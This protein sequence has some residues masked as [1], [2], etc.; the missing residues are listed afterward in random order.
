MFELLEQR[1]IDANRSNFSFI[2]ADNYTRVYSHAL[3]NLVQKCVSVNPAHRPH[4]NE[5]LYETNAGLRN[6]QT[7]YGRVD[8]EDVDERWTWEYR[9]E[10]FRIGEDAPRHWRWGTEEVDEPG[11]EFDDEDDEDEDM[12]TRL[13]SLFEEEVGNEGIAGAGAGA[14]QQDRTPPQ[15]KGKGKAPEEP[16]PAPASNAQ[17]SPSAN[18]LKVV[19]KFGGHAIVER[20]LKGMGS[21]KRK[22]K[23]RAREEGGEAEVEQPVQDAEEEPAGNLVKREEHEKIVENVEV[24]PAEKLNEEKEEPDQ[25]VEMRPLGDK[26]RPSADAHASGE[27]AKRRKSK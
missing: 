21:R 5:L 4:L 8:G 17:Q 9:K 27:G 7:A 20:T 1:S 12:K 11:E 15:S 19:L 3:E 23:E 22:G 25:V 16:N 6:W 10:D 2:H 13:R 14:G 26:K 18:D 24:G